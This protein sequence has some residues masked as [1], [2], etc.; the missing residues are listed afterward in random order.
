MGFIVRLLLFPLKVI[1]WLILVIVCS[2]A[3][4]VLLSTPADGLSEEQRGAISQNC[5]TI[6][7][8]LS[9]LQRVDT[10][11][12]NY[13]GTTYETLV[14]KFIVPLNLRLVKNN[15]A[16]LPHIQSNFSLKQSEFRSTYT[17]YMRE[18]EVLMGRDCQK[19]PDEF[20]EQLEVVRKKRSSLRKITQE[21]AQLAEEQ[22]A[23]VLDLRQKL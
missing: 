5:S 9:Q 20:Y 15:R 23:S 7:Q 12:R 16:T 19:L 14:N 2:I 18:M 22:Y 11:T 4:S 17:E 13:L 10:K 8:S 1:K 3:I 6:K 21:L